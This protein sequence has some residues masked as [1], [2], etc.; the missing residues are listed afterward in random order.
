M[1]EEDKYLHEGDEGEDDQDGGEE[2]V[3]IREE[4]NE[5]DSENEKE[6]G[7]PSEIS[8]K[9]E[10]FRTQIKEKTL[11]INQL[12][13]SLNYSKRLNSDQVVNKV[14]EGV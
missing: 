5:E 2:Q 12:K 1:D 4:E 3:V 11:R 10:L 6:P 8:N 9:L 7:D 14:G 13:E